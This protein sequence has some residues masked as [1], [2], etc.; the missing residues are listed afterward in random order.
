MLAN[1]LLQES[2]TN[3]NLT[4]STII[5][6]TKYNKAFTHP[7]MTGRFLSLPFSIPNRPVAHFLGHKPPVEYHLYKDGSERRE[8]TTTLSTIHHTADWEM[9]LLQWATAALQGGS[10]TMLSHALLSM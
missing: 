3:N 5:S 4:G 8:K 9:L 2:V 10:F 6:R 1:P 7:Y